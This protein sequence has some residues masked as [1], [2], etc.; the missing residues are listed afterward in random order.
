MSSKG[1]L[2]LNSKVGLVVAALSLGGYIWTFTSSLRTM[3]LFVPRISLLL[4][5]LG[6]I[7][8]PVR[9]IMK[10][11]TKVEFKLTGK[12]PYAVIIAF[13]MYA[14][15]WSFRN[16]GL[17]SATFVFLFVWWVWTVYRDAK[18]KMISANLL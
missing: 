7:L 11:E 18:R 13:L 14:Y 2:S 15:S 10:P 3:E 16:I 1:L 12:L 5:V 17:I 9:E 4:M 8:V 6:G